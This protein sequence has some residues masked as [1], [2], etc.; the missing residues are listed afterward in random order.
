MLLITYI[1]FL[2]NVDLTCV[3]TE[4]TDTDTVAAVAP[5]ILDDNVRAVG[6][7]RNAII[8]VVDVRVLD[9]DV[10]RAICV[11]TIESL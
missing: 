9:D 6:L 5:E 3:L 8:T 4:T 2:H 1:D 10:V 7:E 11:P